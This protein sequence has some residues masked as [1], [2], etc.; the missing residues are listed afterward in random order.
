M[1]KSTATRLTRK[2]V[3]GKPAKPE[4]PRP[5]FPLFP[6][7]SGKWAKAVRGKTYYFGRWNDPHGAESEYLAV[8]DD[9]HAGREPR[10]KSNAGGP[11]LRETC[12]AFMRAKRIKMDAGSLSP[13]SFAG[14]DSTCR[15]LLDN[16]GRNRSVAD[17]GPTDFEKLYA[18]LAER[19][20]GAAS[21]GPRITQ[22][23][24]V[25]KYAFEAD[26]IEKPV[27]YGPVFK[28][29]SR[30]ELRKSKGKK[31]QQNGSRTFDADEIRQMLDSA[32]T[33]QLK[34]MILLGI[35]GALGNTDCSSLP[36]SALDLDKGWLDYPR[37][38]TGVERQIPLW[39]ETIAALR[40]VVAQ[41]KEPP[42]PDDE[43]LVFLTRFGQRWVRFELLESKAY[44]KTLIKSKSDD[45][46]AKAT[47]TLLKSLGL[48]RPGLSFY[49][50][51]HT[52]ETIAGG[53][54]DQ[55]AVDAIMGHIDGSMAANYRH[56]IDDDRLRAVAD[57]V[58]SWLFTE[59][60]E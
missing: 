1:S 47:A 29:P 8:A 53:C 39:P 46:I 23:R 35:N 37:P 33:L 30:S 40:T 52:F 45:A 22:V 2:P 43:G 7:A 13:R 3:G 9:L 25:F 51:R 57:H 50:L 59:G 4:K 28:T 38:K 54:R 34:S 10:P 5:D 42:D 24:S 21:L 16:F 48:K 6:H 11:T 31:K 19:Y 58:H 27:K 12:N 17:L 20:H 26:L 18:K 36:V 41:R 14:Y 15:L 56:G 55:L 60:V 32:P 44:G 49:S